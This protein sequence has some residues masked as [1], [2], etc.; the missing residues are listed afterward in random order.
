MLSYIKLNT[1]YLICYKPPYCGAK[2]PK[3]ECFIL[4]ATSNVNSVQ[5]MH[6]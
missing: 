5:K 2:P 6:L 3:V 4:L 1:K